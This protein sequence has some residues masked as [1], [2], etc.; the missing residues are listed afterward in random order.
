MRREIL[1]PILGFLA[2]FIVA[3]MVFWQPTVQTGGATQYAASEVSPS[4][5]VAS[6]APGDHSHR[7]LTV[8]SRE[9]AGYAP[10]AETAP[11]P[12]GAAEIF[13]DTI[14]KLRELDGSSMEGVIEALT[15]Q[16][17]AAGPEGFHALRDYLRTGQ[18]VIFQHGYVVVD[19]KMVHS[20]RTA[21]LNKLGEWPG[22][23]ATELTHEILRTTS[24]R[25]DASIAIRLLEKSAPG[26]CRD[27][28]VQACQRLAGKPFENGDWLTNDMLFDTMK[29]FK[30][31]ELLPVAEAALGNYGWDTMRFITSLDALPDNVR[32]GALQRLFA[33]ETVTKYLPMSS[34]GIQSLNYAEPIIAENMARV[35]AESTDKKSREGFVWAIG[36]PGHEL[37]GSASAADRVAKW[38]ARAAFLESIA[39]LC[40]TPA[41]QERLQDA[42]ASLQKAIAD[43]NDNG[44]TKRGSGTFILNGGANTYSGSAIIVGQGSFQISTSTQKK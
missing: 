1:L 6:S 27:E 39:P 16:L 29:K 38:Q 32:E 12:Q 2:G 33:N 8:T 15:K 14:G 26:A 10:A 5:E 17:H 23:E 34:L 25:A 31:V 20:L 24:S 28:A 3:A 18:D 42:R 30:A 36:E 43:P 11:K 13:H 35:F 22:G 4:H 41:L 7:R 21:L 9:S 37:M 19:G 40:D 44:L